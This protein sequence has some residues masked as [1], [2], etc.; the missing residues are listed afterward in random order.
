MRH[1]KFNTAFVL[2]ALIAA[3]MALAIGFLLGNLKST[4]EGE[5]L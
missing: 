2:S 5:N 4:N 1:D 3:L